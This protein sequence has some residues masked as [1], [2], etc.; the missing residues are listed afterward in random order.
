MPCSMKAS[1]RL[2]APLPVHDDDRQRHLPAAGRHPEAYT[3][4]SELWQYL[5]DHVTPGVYRAVRVNLGGLTDLHFPGGDK[6]VVAT[7]RQLRKIF[8]FN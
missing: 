4:K 6:V 1:A 8:K 5:K 2:Y 3:K 7:Y